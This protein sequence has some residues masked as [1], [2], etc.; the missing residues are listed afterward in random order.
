MEI[1]DRIYDCLHINSEII[2][3]LGNGYFKLKCEDCGEVW[4][5][6]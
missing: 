6:G 1:M 3:D 4:I 5:D 2:E